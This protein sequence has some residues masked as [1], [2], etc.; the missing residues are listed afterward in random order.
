MLLSVVMAAYIGK[1]CWLFHS[2]WIYCIQKDSRGAMHWCCAYVHVYTT[3]HP[4]YIYSMWWCIE[5]KKNSLKVYNTHCSS[6]RDL[7]C[8]S[9]L[10]ILKTF[11]SVHVR[12]K[13]SSTTTADPIVAPKTH[14]GFNN[15]YTHTPLKYKTQYVE[16][17]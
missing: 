8:F 9:F 3:Y 2:F 16:A 4:I 14:S 13:F 12:K 5:E 17:F 6:T 11:L 1:C 7:F 15:L 10:F